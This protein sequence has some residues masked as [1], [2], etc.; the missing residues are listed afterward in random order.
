MYLKHIDYNHL[1]YNLKPEHQPCPWRG[2]QREFFPLSSTH[3]SGLLLLRTPLILP[4]L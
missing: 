4:I 1:V 3:L 2:L